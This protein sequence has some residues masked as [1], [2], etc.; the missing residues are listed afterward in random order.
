MA[1][2]SPERHK[3]LSNAAAP[4]LPQHVDTF[5]K[6]FQELKASI[7]Q[8]L[9]ESLDLSQL[10]VANQR[11]L[12]H[13]VRRV[14]DHVCRVRGEVLSQVDRERLLEGVIDEMFG[15]GPLEP[16]LADPEVTDVLVN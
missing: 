2:V 10:A 15:L 1:T 3:F 11:H 12:E 14:A 6:R 7:H 9:V 5:E 16:L 13:H 8:E 4:P